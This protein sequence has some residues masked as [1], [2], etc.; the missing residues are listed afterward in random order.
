MLRFSASKGSD[1][2]ERVLRSPG[3]RA[4][5]VLL[6][7]PTVDD[8]DEPGPAAEMLAEA[9]R[10]LGALPMVAP[11]GDPDA[12]L[13]NLDVTEPDVV[14]V[15]LQ[16]DPFR[17][18][19]RADDDTHAGAANGSP[20]RTWERAALL[21]RALR[22]A[23]LPVI[24]VSVGASVAAL[25]ACVEQGATGLF[26]PESLAPE[27]VRIA[28][29]NPPPKNSGRAHAPG[30][31]PAPYDALVHLTR[32]ERRVLFQLMEGRLAAEIA[33]SQFVS[34]TTVR[35]HIRAILSKL[36]VNSQLA[37][38]ALAFGTTLDQSA[39]VTQSV[40]AREELQARATFDAVT[41]CCNRQST[42]S[43]LEEMIAAD[44]EHGGP[45]TI[46]V[47][48][49]RF[50]DINDAFGHAAGDDF[51]RVIAARLQRGVRGED[52]VGRIGG[53]EFLV[54]CPG[55]SSPVDAMRTASRLAYALR[56]PIHLKRIS[57]P[58]RASIGLAWSDAPGTTSQKLVSQADV[59]MY[60]SKR[61][62]VGE[63]VLFDESMPGAEDTQLAYSLT[64]SETGS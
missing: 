14:V 6:A 30:H 34:V 47:D 59:A 36:N 32:S 19:R 40:R 2:Q 49:D 37:A 31:L 43:A 5:R 38:V 15:L 35:S 63:P 50:K 13:L 7:A 45:A 29:G 24:A 44:E 25:A 53:D 20:A 3:G 58:S 16:P 52:V 33:S 17:S 61:A 46:F 48:L 18:F 60:A 57:V 12:V 54:L 39:D 42:I 8:Q 56:N 27:L 21:T 1:D 9:V 55:I 11:P 62:G 22:K 4:L 51:L 41:H 10:D 26:Y 28:S 23:E 64:L